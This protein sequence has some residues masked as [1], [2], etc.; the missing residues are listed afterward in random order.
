[1]TAGKVISIIGGIGIIGI[2]IVTGGSFL[3]PYLR[4][5]SVPP[6]LNSEEQERVRVAG[7][8]EQ[9]IVTNKVLVRLTEA[10]VRA[11]RVQITQSP[12]P[13]PVATQAVVDEPSPTPSP[14]PIPEEPSPKPTTSPTA[15]PSPE[16]TASP[17][18]TLKPTSTPEI[19]PET[20]PTPLNDGSVL[21]I[22]DTTT[23]PV[24]PDFAVIEN[25]LENAEFVTATNQQPATD[26]SQSRLTDLLKTKVAVDSTSAIPAI[27]RWI[28][29]DLKGAET[30]VRIN[31]AEEFEPIGEPIISPSPSAEPTITDAPEP[32][33]AGISAESEAALTSTR[34]A[35][36]ALRETN[37]FEHVEPL[38]AA[39]PAA[40]PN[41]PYFTTSGAIGQPYDDLWGLKRIQAPAAWDATTGSS[42]VTIAVLD[43]G[44]DFTHRDLQGNIWENAGET[45]NDALGRDKKTNG[46][47]DDGNGYIDDWRGWDFYNNDNDPTDDS[48]HGTH[49]AG[50]IGA[51][52]N[53]TTDITGTMWNVKI[54]P[55]QF[56]SGD[57]EGTGTVEDAAAGLRYAADK[58]A[59]VIN[60]SW[61]AYGTS[62]L[63]HDAVEY[64]YSKGSLITAAAGNESCDLSHRSCWGTPAVEGK[65]IAVSASTPHDTKAPFSNYGNKIELAAPGGD[66]GEFEQNSILSL[67]A[68]GTSGYQPLNEQLAFLSGTSA[69]TP[70]VSGVAGLVFALHP[71]WT[72]EQVRTHLQQTADDLGVSG[73]DREFGYGLVNAARAVGRD[74]L[75]VNMTAPM[76]Y[77]ILDRY[78]NQK[79]D[80]TGTV[81]GPA[82]RRYIVEVDQGFT[83]PTWTKILDSTTP[84]NNGLLTQWTPPAQPV[85]AV[86]D[87][88]LTTNP[89][90]PE[91]IQVLRQFELD[92]PS[93][94]FINNDD[95][96]TTSPT[97]TLTLWAET[98]SSTN[99]QMRIRNAGKVWGAWQPYADTKSWTLSAG[100]GLKIVEVE[101]N[102][103]GSNQIIG[104]KDQIVVD[105][106]GTTNRPPK[107]K[108]GPFSDITLPQSASLDGTVADDGRP[109]P[110]GAV[111]TTWSKV[112]GPGNVTFS[113]QSAVDTTATFSAAGSY[114]L[115][116]MATDGE[117]T[118][119]DTAVVSV[120]DDPRPLSYLTATINRP[121]FDE[122]RPTIPQELLLDFLFKHLS[123]NNL[124]CLSV[125]LDGTLVTPA[126][127]QDAYQ[128]TN[129]PALHSC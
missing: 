38:L 57:G 72:N 92:K 99:K 129:A 67:R 28:V 31:N 81:N 8:T 88:R 6:Q 93:A 110:P 111:T 109:T 104:H 87:M 66:W 95:D 63:I 89:G 27:D 128:Q 39:E 32:Q 23:V 106:S 64:A 5:Q 85:N 13:T 42:S 53:N 126:N 77:T 84:V 29:L 101:F 45:G 62:I 25:I 82:L 52:G 86:F 114:R 10:Q 73:R 34:D 80:V 108:A 9:K 44:I 115:Q 113:N 123:N 20:S 15:S 47:D 30:V 49:V 7:Q 48:G 70:H 90:T 55:L 33:R 117:H 22:Q 74:S 37:L 83:P 12:T 35:I 102:Y 71:D 124:E 79:I 125:K 69:A 98:Y 16:E 78:P 118:V 43:T 94:V 2:F 21:G 18:P 105:T 19:S 97:V 41:D 26:A 116:L 103:G 50:T 121:R 24:I 100:N 46:V 65:V 40:T 4:T 68:E 59:K 56:L 61:G 17:S 122:R 112:S 3:A 51:R 60:N 54:M 11:I 76:T 1:M 96:V 127:D 75:Q 107:V 58:G 14:S 119:S 91:R 120:G 36:Q